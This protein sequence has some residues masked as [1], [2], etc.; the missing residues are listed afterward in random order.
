MTRRGCSV[1]GC[2]RSHSARGLCHAHWQRA[3]ARGELDRHQPSHPPTILAQVAADHGCTVPDLL[4]RDRSRHLVAAR[5]DAAHRLR[6]LDLST[7]EIG[8]LLGGRDHTTILNALSRPRPDVEARPVPDWSTCTVPSCERD[9]KTAG[10]CIGHYARWKR[11]GDISAD[12]PLRPIR[13]NDT[14]LDLE[15]HNKTGYRNGCRCETCRADAVRAV[16]RNRHNPK[17]VPI[18]EGLA[19]LERAR[20]AGMSVPRIARRVGVGT[21]CL[22]HW[23]SGRAATC[24]RETVAAINA[25]APEP[26]ARVGRPPSVPIERDACEDCDRPSLGG[27]RWCIDHFYAHARR[28]S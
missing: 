16:K 1:D 22:Y 10:M 8:R 5:I 4:G 11:H 28:A 15:V 24:S 7:P 12:V 2:T 6:D 20:A 13:E 9:S 26:K 14:V 19:A 17:R 21:A 3:K 27:G 23:L 25:L 18:D